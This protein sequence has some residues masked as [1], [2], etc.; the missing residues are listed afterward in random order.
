MTRAPVDSAAWTGRTHE[1]IAHAAWRQYRGRVSH[2]ALLLVRRDNRAAYVNRW[3]GFEL[4][5]DDGLGLRLF[6]GRR[7]ALSLWLRARFGGG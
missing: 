2:A 5:C 6:F 7:S 1:W 4:N 3:Y